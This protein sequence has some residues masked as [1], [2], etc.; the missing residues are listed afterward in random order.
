[1]VRVWAQS[2]ER[3]R[4][5]SKLVNIGVNNDI[6]DSLGGAQVAHTGHSFQ[7][8]MERSGSKNV[9]TWQ[10]LMGKQS[11]RRKPKVQYS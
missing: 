9:A 7:H 2:K 11:T 4:K 6:G 3:H 5:L 8:T 1:M 10:G